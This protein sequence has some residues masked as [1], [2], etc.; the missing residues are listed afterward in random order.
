[1]AACLTDKFEIKLTKVSDL[2]DLQRI[3]DGGFGLV[4]KAMHSDWGPVAFKK[5]KVRHLNDCN[6]YSNVM[7]IGS[8][9]G[10]V[11][12][13]ASFDQY[14]LTARGLDLFVPS[15]KTLSFKNSFVMCCLFRFK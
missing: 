10:C 7:F 6:R 13:N 9:V 12:H 5:L 8:F 4:Y 14:N 2:K 1:M 3:G 11:A 15:S